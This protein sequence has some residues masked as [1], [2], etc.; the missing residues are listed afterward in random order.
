M[1][2]TF[3]KKRKLIKEDKFELFLQKEKNLTAKSK[4]EPIKEEIIDSKPAIQR[5]KGRSKT[6]VQ[7]NSIDDKNTETVEEINVIEKD[8]KVVNEK[9]DKPPLADVF[10]MLISQSP[11][12]KRRKVEMKSRG[13]SQ[14][15][16]LQETPPESSQPSENPPFINDSQVPN[17]DQS[18]YEKILMSDAFESKYKVT[19]MP[20]VKKLVNTYLSGSQGPTSQTEGFQSQTHEIECDDDLEE[21]EVDEGLESS[22]D[23]LPKIK[24]YHHLKESGNKQMILDEIEYLMNGL[25]S[26]TLKVK[27]NSLYEL[28]SKLKDDFMNMFSIHGYPEKLFELFHMAEDATL[29]MPLILIFCKLKSELKQSEFCQWL[30][31]TIDYFDQWQ[32]NNKVLA[33]KKPVDVAHKNFIGQ[34]AQDFNTLDIREIILKQL[35]A[36]HLHFENIELSSNQV[37]YFKS[38]I[39]SRSVPIY[40]VIV[41]LSKDWKQVDTIVP[42][43]DA[44]DS[45]EISGDEFA[46]VLSILINLYCKDNI[47]LNLP[48]LNVSKLF[49]YLEQSIPNDTINLITCFLI[50]IAT[51]KTKKY[52][53]KQIEIL[54]KNLEKEFPTNAYTSILMASIYMH[55]NF[56]FDKERALA[57]LEEF[58]LV[59]CDI[60]IRN[61]QVSELINKLKDF[62]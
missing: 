58:H 2:T 59:Q 46:D 44:L 61:D 39:L 53:K 26:K 23:D 32:A 4:V 10:S 38:Q 14:S 31:N 54:K 3:A 16:E 40:P 27:R 55:Q 25:T 35:S 42:F 49:A 60:G 11:T 36:P 17:D 30:L 48:D 15:S 22:D 56:T 51:I 24:A 29:R 9:I 19:Q 20:G 52:T 33:R 37:D 45:L 7:D 57:N 13:V 34:I 12:K 50:N 28:Y 21:T 18:A 8:I 1:I 47:S 62:A 43:Y 5:R 6:V 41:K